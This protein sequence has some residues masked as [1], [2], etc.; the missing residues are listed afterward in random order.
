MIA[1]LSQSF[2]ATSRTWV[3]K[4][5][6]PPPSQRSRIMP[7]RMC[8]ALGSSPT[9]GS[10]MITSR[11]AP[12]G[13]D[14]E[15]LLHAVGVRRD[16][17]GEVARQ[18]KGVRVLPDALAPL[19]CADAEDVR[20]EVQVFFAGHIV[21]KVRIIR[22]VREDA[23]AAERIGADVLPADGDLPGIEL[24]NA[25]DRLQRRRLACAVMTDEAINL[26]WRDMQ[27]QIVHGALFAVSLREMRN[28]Q[29]SVSFSFSS[30]SPQDFTIPRM[31]WKGENKIS[32]VL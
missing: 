18:L 26:P 11:V 23:L 2:S 28:M 17:L 16:G 30:L 1:T 7:F 6:A 14:G 24:Q 19:R 20:D 12:R 22:N 3:E 5:I 13:D 8:A 31:L 9:K 10:S 32:T 4:K 27:A 15:L 21:V 29:H 25:D